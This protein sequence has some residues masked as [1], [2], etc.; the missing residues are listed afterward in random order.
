MWLGRALALVT[1]VLWIGGS[2]RAEDFWGHKL[3]HEPTEFIFGY[4]SLI[5][6]A[7]RNSTAANPVTAIPV[8]VSAAF[9]YIRTWNDR[10]LSGFTALGLRRAGPGENG[11]TINGV[12]YPVVGHDMSAFDAREKGYI[13]VEVPH[14]DIEA[15]SWQAVPAEGK[16][17]T[18]VPEHGS[19]PDAEYPLLQSYIDVVIE[20]GL[21]YS[22][23]FAREVIQTTDGWSEYWLNDRRLARR[24][25]V[26]DRVYQM[27]DEML[28]AQAPHFADRRFPE[29]YTA[30]FLCRNAP[31]APAVD[32]RVGR[33]QSGP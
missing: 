10:S 32:E 33:S 17:W 8:R 22:P 3:E 29:D 18:Y 5:D 13:R 16:I 24:P 21:E 9:G 30:R 6:S 23:D 15:V 12:I 7:S 25:W 1:L 2:P 19:G 4:G 20:G 11:M 26:F 31:T 28:A 14:Q 27:A